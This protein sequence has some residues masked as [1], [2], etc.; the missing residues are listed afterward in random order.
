MRLRRPGITARA[1][2][3]SV[4]QCVAVRSNALQCAAVRCS[5]VMMQPCVDQFILLCNLF[6]YAIGGA[7]CLGDD[8]VNRMPAVLPHHQRC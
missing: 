1:A 5:H 2:C 6:F 4:L 3:Y 7:G 8:R